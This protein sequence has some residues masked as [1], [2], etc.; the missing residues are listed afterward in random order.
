MT[1][2]ELESKVE[3][4]EST[5]LAGSADNEN[6]MPATPPATPSTAAVLLLSTTT[7]ML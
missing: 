7:L 5:A 6:H 3:K 2:E 1:N 4:V